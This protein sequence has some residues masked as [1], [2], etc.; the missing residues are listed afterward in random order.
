MEAEVLEVRQQQIRG[1]SSIKT[2][3]MLGRTAVEDILKRKK[4]PEAIFIQNDI[5]A[6]S[7]MNAITEAGIRVPEELV[8]ITFGDDV[9]LETSRPTLTSIQFPTAQVAREA[10]LLLSDLLVNP[11]KPPVKKLLKPPVIFRESC[12]K[13]EGFED[14]SDF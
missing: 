9:L 10:V 11:L 2:I 8:I 3:A 1:V 14:D 13:P 5:L 6:A 7:F 4:L 12:P